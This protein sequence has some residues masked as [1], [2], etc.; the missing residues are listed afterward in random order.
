MMSLRRWMLIF[1]IIESRCLWWSRESFALC[2]APE[3]KQ[4]VFTHLLHELG[5]MY[6]MFHHAEAAVDGAIV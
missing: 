4:R 6:T 5:G 3:M 2:K 1:F